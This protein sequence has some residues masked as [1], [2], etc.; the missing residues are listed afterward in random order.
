[1][2]HKRKVVLAALAPAICF[3]AYCDSHEADVPCPLRTLHQHVKQRNADRRLSANDLKELW[4]HLN[5][6]TEVSA[7]YVSPGFFKR[8]GNS[9]QVPVEIEM[10]RGVVTNPL[11]GGR[12]VQTVCEVGFNAG[13]SAIVWLHGLDTKLK[14]FDLF[15]LPYSNA[16]RTYISEQYADRVEF[17]HG[18]SQL[19][20]PNYTRSVVAGTQ[21]LCDVWFIDG[22]HYRKAPETDLK[23]ALQASSDGA[24]IIADDCTTRF[25]MVQVAWR[26]LL[27]TGV[28]SGRIEEPYNRTINMPPPGGLK[29]W[30][31]GRYTRSSSPS[32]SPAA[33]T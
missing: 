4:L 15:K 27:Q 20:V 22:D 2:S 30:C 26:H 31:V 6:A 9:A 23:N 32:R 19:T 1:M 8:N 33:S 3:A 14:S 5:A 21:P 10:L 13:H 16:S 18:P 25:P 24:I 7:R 12:Q 28:S 29:G 17:F 11:Q